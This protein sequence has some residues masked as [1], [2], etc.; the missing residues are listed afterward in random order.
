MPTQEHTPSRA[1]S[2]NERLPK[3]RRV[4]KRSE[5]L[6]LQ[7]VAR[8]RGSGR[9]VVLTARSRHPHSR[10]GVTTSRRVGNAV[11]RNR[12]KRLVREIFRKSQHDI[13]PPQDV[14]VIARPEAAAATYAD[15]QH[16]IVRA[17]RLEVVS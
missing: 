5:Y 6:R 9:L 1:P 4:R 14:L 10:L 15:L 16:E 12:I 3:E 17:L 11:V 13:V 8:R 7:R 2:R